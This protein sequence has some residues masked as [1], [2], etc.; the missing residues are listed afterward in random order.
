MLDAFGR[1]LFFGSV[2]VAIVGILLI[3]VLMLG[4]RIDR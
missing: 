3:A 2:A 1:I 4:S